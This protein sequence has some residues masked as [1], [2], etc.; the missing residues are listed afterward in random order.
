[1][2][3]IA[4]RISDVLCL[5]VAERRLVWKEQNSLSGILTRQGGILG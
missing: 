5:R 2:S 1:M 3:C 4:N